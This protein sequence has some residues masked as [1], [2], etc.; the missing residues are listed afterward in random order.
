MDIFGALVRGYLTTAGEFLN[1]AEKEHLVFSARLITFEIGI[2]FLTDHLLGDRYFKI[3][4]AG[5]NVDRARVQ[6][7]M[8]ES[9]ER[10]EAAMDNV[11]KEAG[12]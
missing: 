10:H 8:I 1:T 9:F 6:F 2:R 5:H 11:V 3:H 4:R 12:G 7:K